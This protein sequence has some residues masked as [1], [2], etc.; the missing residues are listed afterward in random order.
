MRNRLASATGVSLPAGLVFDHPTP[1]ALARHLLRRLTDAP[2]PGPATRTATPSG[3]A[4]DEPVAIVAMGCRYPGGVRSPEDLWRLL[5][6]GT[7]AI[8]GFPED[9]GWNLDLLSASGGTAGSSS[10]LQGGFLYD[11][12]EFD[13]AFFG[14]SP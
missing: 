4:T 7:D 2:R 6:T 10:T 14:I 5:T 12:A 1:D 3:T 13:A 8:G 9:R 11:A